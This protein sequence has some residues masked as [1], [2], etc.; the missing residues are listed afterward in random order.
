MDC[1]ELCPFI[2]SNFNCGITRLTDEQFRNISL[3]SRINRNLYQTQLG[4]HSLLVNIINYDY[5]DDGTDLQLNSQIKSGASKL[6]VYDGYY[7][8][9][10]CILKLMHSGEANIIEQL[11]Q[12]NNNYVVKVFRK[13]KREE[14]NFKINSNLVPIVMEKLY[15]LYLHPHPD[16][17]DVDYNA[18]TLELSFSN[19]NLLPL[20]K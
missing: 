7:Q 18:E 8:G 12:K 19:E 5:I 9:N 3:Q 4:N 13:F 6:S 2:Q 20:L 11:N 1:D 17:V 15:P 10:P 14:L 16:T